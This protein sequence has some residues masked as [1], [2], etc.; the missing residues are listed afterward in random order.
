M[1]NDFIN[2][3]Y[4]D[5]DRLKPSEFVRHFADDATF[6]YGNGPVLRGPA[7]IE[8]MMNT[9]LS[10]IRS[11]S[12]EVEDV[13]T[14]GSKYASQVRATFTRHNGTALTLPGCSIIERQVRGIVDYRVYIDSSEL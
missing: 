2:N 10:Q 13:V 5:F 4:R 11:I 9:L 8:E 7:Q 3:L 14:D 12:H 1:R 6:A